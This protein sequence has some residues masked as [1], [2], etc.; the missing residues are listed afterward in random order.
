MSLLKSNHAITQTEVYKARKMQP[1]VLGKWFEQHLREIFRY[2]QQETKMHWVRLTDSSDAGSIVQS[3]D[4]DFIVISDGTP[5]LVEAKCSES[6][7]SLQS[8]A[9][10]MVSKQQA[11]SHRLWNRAGG[12]SVFVFGSVSAD[13]FELWVGQHVAEQRASGSKL[14]DDETY[15]SHGVLTGVD[16]CEQLREWL[17]C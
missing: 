15:V 16:L 14:V 2:L 6:H 12:E 3:T 5:W 7:A 9:A 17:V 1:H 8:C 10:N 13:C 4:G 11:M